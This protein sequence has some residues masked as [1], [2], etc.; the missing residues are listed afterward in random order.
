MDEIMEAVVDTFSVLGPNTSKVL[1]FH[2]EKSYGLRPDEIPSRPKDFHDALKTIFGKYS[3]ILELSICR[4][5]RGA[6]PFHNSAFLQFFE[7]HSTLEVK[8]A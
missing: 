5:I 7:R 1:M 2:L 4:Q 8:V 6:D 3:N